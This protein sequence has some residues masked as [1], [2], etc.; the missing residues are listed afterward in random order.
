VLGDFLVNHVGNYLGNYLGEYAVPFGLALVVLTGAFAASI[1]SRRRYVRSADLKRGIEALRLEFRR[2]IEETRA[3]AGR[4]TTAVRENLLSVIKPIDST[5][6]DLAARLVR[7]EEHADAVDTFMTGPQKQALE[8]NEQIAARLTKLEQKLKAVTD[9]LSLVEQTIDGATVRDRDRNDSIEAMNSRLMNT[10]KKVDELFPRLELGERARIDLGTLIGLFVKQLK[11]VNLNSAETALRVAD[12]ESL[13]SKVTGLE[14][15]LTSALLGKDYGSTEDSAGDINDVVTDTTPKTG[16][17]A[18]SFEASNG[19]GN[20]GA[21]EE[22]PT[23]TEEASNESS[24]EGEGV[25]GSR[26]ETGVTNELHEA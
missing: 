18:G 7:L 24:L 5:L 9:E 14:E 23:S 26:P 11:R 22:S 1:V 16:D 15:R 20:A 25:S 21:A 17:G 12:L 3:T 10:Q 4:K 19:S 13:R 2:S 8:A 6:A